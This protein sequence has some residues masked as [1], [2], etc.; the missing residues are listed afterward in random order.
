MADR[1]TAAELRSFTMRDFLLGRA[2]RLAAYVRDAELTSA[3]KQAITQGVAGVAGGVATTGVYVGARRPAGRRRAAAGRGRDGDFSDP[4]G[5]VLA[6]DA[7]VLGEPLLRGRPVLLR[8]PGLLRGRREPARRRR[9]PS[10]CPTGFDEIV[11]SQVTFTYPGADRADPARGQPADRPRPGGGAGRRERLG[12]DDARQGAGGPVP[13]RL[14]L[15][16]WDATPVREVDPDLLREQI[17]VI[18]Q[19]HANWPLSV[20]HNITMGRD[21]DAGSARRGGR[22][23]RCRRGDRQP[24]PRLQHAARPDASRT[25]PNSPAASGSESRSPAATT[26]RRR[27]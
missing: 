1:R 16:A 22:R 5:P 7:A 14:R 9:A 17:A 15:G 24:R 25:A 21:L 10:Q 23:R 3:R 18:A 6:G 13:A 12:Q 20:R 8:L 27:C 2:S 26:G 19:D 11:A 4:L